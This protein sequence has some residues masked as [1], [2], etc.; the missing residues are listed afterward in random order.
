[1]W[2]GLRLIALLAVGL[3]AASS[4]ASA[5]TAW[6]VDPTG[7]RIGFAGEH[8][9]NKFKGTFGSWDAAIAFDPADLAGS[10]AT[11]TVALVSAKTGD[12]TY[13]KTM[14]TADW[15]DAVKAPSAVFETT[16]FRSKGGDAFEADG[17]LRIR[18]INVPVVLAFTFTRSGDTAKLT[19][20]TR[21][22]RLDFG[23][24]KSSDADG[25]WVSLDI[26]VEIEVALKKG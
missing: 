10:K 19:G 3:I 26:P 16:A 1:M 17:T 20:S 9:G 21:L 6:V 23:I 22:K 7:S 24:G 2:I 15:F 4:A 11:V 5:A 8:A 14:P 18:G 25:A 12:A 13:D